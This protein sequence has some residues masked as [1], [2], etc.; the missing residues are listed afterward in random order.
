MISIPVFIVIYLLTA[1]TVLILLP[2][3][4]IGLGKVVKALLVAWS[5]LVFLSMGKRLRVHG[6]HHV[7][8]NERYIL[9]ANHAS[10]FDIMAIMAFYPGVAWFGRE[11]LLKI[12]VFGSLLKMINYVPMKAADLRNTKE[13]IAQLTKSTKG[14]TVAIFPEGTRTLDGSINNFKKGFLHVLKAT[15]LSIL[16][17]TLNG[18]YRFKPKDRFYIN[19]RS[20]LGVVVHPP[21][22]K[23]ELDT[24]TDIEIVDYVRS[25]IE[26]AYVPKLAK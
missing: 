3:A 9:I 4:I 18:F 1:I 15:E 19:F 12:P 6:R 11:H 23:E 24:K 7:S 10:L 25:I 2:F 16:P 22:H 26:S 20:R 8:K 14:N 17:V 5:H 21:I 13:M